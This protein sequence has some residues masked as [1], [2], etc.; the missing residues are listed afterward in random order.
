[1]DNRKKRILVSPLNWGLGHAVRDIPLI[2][3]LINNNYE[4]I[5]AGEGR[6]GKLLKK[7]FPKLKFVKL[8][9]FSVNYSKKNLFFLKLLIQIPGILKGIEREHNQLKTI[10][11]DFEIDLIISDNRYG[12][13]SENCPSIFITHQ[14]FLKS[15]RYLKFSEKI[16]FKFHKKRIDKFDKCLIPDF[17]DIPNLS[18]TLSHGLKLG[19]KYS[20]IGLLSHFDFEKNDADNF[21]YDIAIIISGPE[22]QRRIFEKKI[23][24]QAVQ[25]GQKVVL[26]SGMPEKSFRKEV[27]NLTIYSH[28]SRT[29]MKEILLYSK[30]VIS[31]SGYTTIM[32]LVKLRKKAILIPTP[33]QTEQEYLANY[34]TDSKLFVFKTQND[35]N[36][37]ESIDELRMLKPE[38]EIFSD[39]RGE[40][41]I[42]HV[43]SM[44]FKEGI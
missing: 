14:I 1:M 22:P 23:T 3:S 2:Y 35:F 7:E 8:P 42:K 29:K 33:G 12:L 10:I 17:S 37:S 19:E 41:F 6:S 21:K 18:G 13:Y 44:F 24:D 43:E 40:D 28:V 32:D 34:L 38:F 30:T 36:L 20:F 39:L 26:V 9:S 5:I 31:R 15:P 25:T 27:Q 16:L 4:V 11:K